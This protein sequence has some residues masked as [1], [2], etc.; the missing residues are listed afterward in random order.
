MDAGSAEL[1][2]QPMMARGLRGKPAQSPP[3]SLPGC[4]PV[5]VSVDWALVGLQDG[6]ST[7]DKACQGWMDIVVVA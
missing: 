2:G 1:V 5:W 7:A 4:V 6:V 3:G